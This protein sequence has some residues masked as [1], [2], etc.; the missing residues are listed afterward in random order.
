[1]KTR[2][3]KSK[4]SSPLAASP[5]TDTTDRA[6][7]SKILDNLI[8]QGSGK[9]SK[10]TTR[11]SHRAYD[12]LPKNGPYSHHFR[13]LLNAE[14]LIA[15]KEFG[16]A[17]DIYQRLLHKIPVRNVRDKIEKNIRDI[18]QQY[19]DYQE[20][21]T[22]KIE[23]QLTTP[24]PPQQGNWPQPPVSGSQS[25]PQSESMGSIN[26]VM[27]T[28]GQPG[29]PA[30]Q[31][32]FSSDQ[33]YSS[34]AS[35]MSSILQQPF[36]QQPFPN[37][38]PSTTGQDFADST[39]KPFGFFQQQESVK[40]KTSDSE[41]KKQPESLFDSSQKKDDSMQITESAGATE[42]LKEIAEAIFKIEKAIFETSKMDVE[43]DQAEAT[44]GGETSSP[45][46][47]KT[48][49]TG[50][51]STP[52]ATSTEK[53]SEEQGGAL[54]STE[55]AIE[56][57]ASSTQTQQS[58]TSTSPSVQPESGSVTEGGSET[59]SEE[60]I[61]AEASEDSEAENLPTDE[62]TEPP[63]EGVIGSSPS[64]P[65]LEESGDSGFSGEEKTE[66]Q[67][68]QE[69][70][71]VL[72]LREPEQEDTPFIT[73]TYD[74]TKIP[75]D[76]YLSRDYN[77]LEYAYYKYKP[78]LVKAQKFIRKK[79]ITKALNYYRVISD[80]NI[81][82]ALKTMVDKNIMDISAYLEKY[83]MTRPG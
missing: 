62:S 6:S 50:K 42:A 81:P 24:P 4:T 78:M 77:I 66:K 39:A 72:E 60:G 37:T 68:I 53:K 23:I 3:P 51:D 76:F 82:S 15:Q 52:G 40:S 7:G 55:K 10:G 25:Q 73:L 54:S 13:S 26:I 44:A 32:N 80:Q 11:L 30:G 34:P 29:A 47:D 33:P 17:I 22:P 56:G 48:E 14:A 61:A 74:F 27:G 67:D 36:I 28:P 12:I 18:E 75:H 21:K 31:P 38:P 69:I 58:K 57:E 1:M 9:E 2:F 45:G 79:Q 46:K 71:G 63:S 8:N 64:I 5:R 35:L 43:S 41:Q 59:V 83:L 19:S 16:T 70:R 20:T 65:S 49:K